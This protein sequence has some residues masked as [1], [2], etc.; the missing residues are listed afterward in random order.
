VC[1]SPIEAYRPSRFLAKHELDEIKND[2]WTDDLWGKRGASLEST[3]NAINEPLKIDRPRLFF[4]FAESDHW[5]AEKTRSAIIEARSG[6]H[7]IQAEPNGNGQAD[8]MQP[9]AYASSLMKTRTRLPE[10]RIDN[11]NI[12]HAFCLSE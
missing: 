9:V 5:V 12:P 7:P 8:S 3:M 1:E 2:K 11:N 4:Y 10:M 6:E